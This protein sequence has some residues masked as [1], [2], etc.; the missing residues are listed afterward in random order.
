MREPEPHDY[1]DQDSDY[2]EYRRDKGPRFDKKEA[3]EQPA[4]EKRY[5]DNRPKIECKFGAA[6]TREDCYFSHPP[7]RERRLLERQF[8]KDEKDQRKGRKRDASPKN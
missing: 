6:C 2:D 5:A 1:P 7:D 8:K 4:L 3:R